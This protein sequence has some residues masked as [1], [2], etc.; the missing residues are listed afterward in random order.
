MGTDNEL[1]YSLV[2]A[3]YLIAGVLFIL[4]L[5]GLAHQ[6]SAKAGNI[7]GKIGMVIALAA[8]VA[9]SLLESEQNAA[10]TASL[11]AAALLIGAVI[12]TRVA[13]RVEMTH[14]PEMIA[15]L[16]SFVG[17]AAVLVGINSYLTESGTEA[18]SDAVHL[19][20]VFL[21]VFIGAVTFTGSIIAYL[22]LSAKI[23]SAP[24]TLPGRNWLN[25][26]VL[27]ASA[28]LLAWYLAAPS[29]W[30][31]AIMTVLAL[32]LG[33]HLVAAIGG[34]DMP[35]VVSM[36]N[37]YSGWAAAAAGF[38][39]SNNLSFIA[40]ILGGFGTETGTGSAGDQDLGEHH[41]TTPAQL[42]ELLEDAQSIVIAPGY[43][44]AVAK[45]QNQV[46]ELTER[47][48]HLGKQVR[49]AVHPVA[50]RLPGH[51]NVLLAEARVPYD[52]VLE[53]D[54][55][56]D[57]LAETDVVLVIGANDTVNPAAEEDPTS[58]IAGMPVLQVWKA[59]HVVVFK[60]SMATGYAGVQNPL[61][62][63]ENTSM[64]FGDAKEQVEQV[65]HAVGAGADLAGARG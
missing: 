55:I 42:A 46:A 18:S 1:L 60:R 39:L 3:A 63:K 10:I 4:S 35:V 14:M 20:E 32:L 6:R 34:G 61:F 50:G 8:T 44:M 52:I 31:L 33:L 51:M 24:L 17:L 16:H 13:R 2:Q 27:V 56:Q 43:G 30:P 15:I 47:L 7:A 41:E 65:A 22:K 64:L 23:K 21:G 9:L 38:M 48:R 40:V 49:F 36:L 5:A 45:A 53:M 28:V 29:I 59:K 11:I 12:G 26:G 54:E 37:S 62:Y 57:E 25:L 19:V 58:P